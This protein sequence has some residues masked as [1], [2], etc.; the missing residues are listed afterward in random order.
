[1]RFFNICGPGQSGRYGMVIPRFVKHALL[2]QPINVY[3]DGLQTRSFTHVKDAVGAI[4][5][6]ANNNKAV[7][8][9][10]NLGNTR[11]ISINDLAKK[12][13]KLTNSK[14][15]VVHI[16]YERAYEK[17]FEDM[18]HRRPDISKL[19]KAIGFKPAHSIED[20][21]KDVVDYFKG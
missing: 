1:M 18:R 11:A 5:K 3:G 21:L 15:P 7:G 10:F 17:G 4:I 19:E 14:S 2:G 12:V 6:L 9:V 20:I 16:P 13:K 8:E